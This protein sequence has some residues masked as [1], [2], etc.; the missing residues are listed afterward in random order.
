MKMLKAKEQENAPFYPFYSPARIPGRYPPQLEK[1]LKRMDRS[2]LPA[3]GPQGFIIPITCPWLVS[4]DFFA[5]LGLPLSSLLWV[6]RFEK[7]MVC[8]FL[9]LTDF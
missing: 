9:L 7:V 6:L 8:M 1:R 4:S 5:H 3:L 2:C